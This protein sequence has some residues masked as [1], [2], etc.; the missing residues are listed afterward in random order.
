ME[1]SGELHASVSL[2]PKRFSVK[3]NTLETGYVDIPIE[4]LETISYKSPPQS[5]LPLSGTPD[6][7]KK[8]H[9]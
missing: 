2:L 1:V 6:K 3:L 7:E 9:W 4:T 5:K 8:S